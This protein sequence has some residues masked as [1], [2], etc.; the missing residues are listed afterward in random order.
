[1]IESEGGEVTSYSDGLV[2]LPFNINRSKGASDLR[3]VG[4]G[5]LSVCLIVSLFSAAGVAQ[6]AQPQPLTLGAAVDAALSNY[7]SIR[8]SRAQA[9]AAGAGIDLA[10]TAYL[11][12]ADMLWQQN[13][14][15]RNNVFGLLFPQSVIPPI[16]GPQLDTTSM[17]G[18]A[19]SAGGLL[20]TWE[21]FDFGLRRA[22]VELARATRTQ[23]EAGV[24]VTR[25]DVATTAADAFLGVLAAEQTVEAAQ[26]NVER[27]ETFA[28]AV[29]ALV[30]NQLRPGVDISRA[31][32]ELAAARNQLILAEQNA[33]VSRAVLAETLGRAGASPALDA[34]PLLSL[35]AS[36]T[37][38]APDLSAHPL[39]LAQAAA[40][41]T[42]RARMRFVDS[43]YFPRFNLQSAVF[44]RGT[45]ALLNGNFDYGKG[46]YPSA[47]NWAVGMTITFP[48]FDIFGIRARRRI[49]AS[50]AAV[51][52]ARYDQAVNTLKTQEARARALVEA[53][54]RIAENTPTQL[55][56][57]QETEQRARVRY[58]NGLTNV[59]EVADAQ[60]LLAQAEVDTAVARLGVWRALLAAARIRGDIKPFLQKVASAPSR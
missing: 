28:R 12:R 14:A 23:A 8:A 32:A 31:N 43:S 24:E 60:R 10:R 30:N 35:P 57:A 47:A 56:A 25:L 40:V 53:A 19:G 33:E 50:N 54:R 5:F 45:S 44:A 51:E 1:M 41:E 3:K 46:W 22:G 16:S 58:E 36:E 18:A 59:V 4:I 2:K 39:A 29:Q 26:A 7:P 17:R 38:A 21:P 42:A 15:T 9:D 49:E 55:R 52:E 13:M 6:V 34:G 48:T 27:M 20:L 37:V 11:P